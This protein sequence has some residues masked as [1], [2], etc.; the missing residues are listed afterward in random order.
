LDVI[1]KRQ[2]SS[3]KGSDKGYRNANMPHTPIE[4][5]RTERNGIFGIGEDEI[6]S[7]CTSH[8]ER[9]YLTAG[10]ASSGTQR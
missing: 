8:V 6:N 2:E 10:Q 9:S 5:V 1:F 7:I 3:P 4:I